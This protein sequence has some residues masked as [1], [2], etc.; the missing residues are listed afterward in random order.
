MMRNLCLEE[1]ET[2]QMDNVSLSVATYAKFQPQS[3]EFLDITNPK[4]VYPFYNFLKY[5]YASKYH[6]FLCSFLAF[7]SYDFKT[8]FL[9]ISN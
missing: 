3:V 8:Y 5:K 9:Q 6:I 1:G 7:C 2:V 4:A